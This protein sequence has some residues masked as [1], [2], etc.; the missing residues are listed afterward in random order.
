MPRWFLTPLLAL[1]ATLASAQDGK[2]L[3]EQNCAACHLPDQMVVG[4]LAH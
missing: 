4:P 2:L 3:Y 1:S